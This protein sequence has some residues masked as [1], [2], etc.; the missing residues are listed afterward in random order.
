M[1]FAAHN[2]TVKCDPCSTAGFGIP[3]FNSASI[4][5]QKLNSHDFFVS[6]PPKYNTYIVLYFIYKYNTNQVKYC[7]K[8]VGV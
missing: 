8:D 6:H 1:Q 7:T 3:G 2:T 5:Y 4:A